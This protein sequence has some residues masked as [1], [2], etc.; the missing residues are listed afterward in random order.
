MI[1]PFRHN[2]RLIDY[3][4]GEAKLR[5]ALGRPPPNI[6]TAADTFAVSA[7]TLRQVL[8]ETFG[9]GTTLLSVS[10]QPR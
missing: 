9:T 7:A 10:E 5:E 3:S 1:V 4:V 6:D 8:N 2:E